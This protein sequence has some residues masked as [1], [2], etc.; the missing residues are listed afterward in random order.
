[1]SIQSFTSVALL[2]V[3]LS[4]T[5]A[6]AS[7][8][9]VTSYDMNNGNGATQYTTPTGGQNYFDFTYTATGQ[10]S[11]TS[12]AG[13]NG[14]ASSIPSNPSHDAPLTGGTGKLTDGI[15]ASDNYSLVSSSNGTISN[16]PA[17][18]G[19]L[20]GQ[21]TQYVGWKYQDPSIT[22]NLAS[23]HLISQISLY[24]AANGS[25]GLVGAPGNVTLNLGG[26]LLDPSLY[27]EVTSPYKPSSNPYASSTDVI[28]ITLKQAVSSD[29]AFGL[30]LFRGALE[31]D[32]D[33]YEA[34]YLNTTTNVFN[35]TLSGFQENAW[36]PKLEPW[37]MLSE[38]E[39]TSAVP[40]P[41]TWLMMIAGFVGLAFVARRKRAAALPQARI[42]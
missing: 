13:K 17:G 15:K 24:V 11:P 14:S 19:F 18:Y 42:A 6:L 9:P 40:E 22:F 29:L 16:S 23:G 4:S 34:Q 30:Q 2:A 35:D 32:G 27:T 33:A 1:M 38:V 39:F 25:G 37:I 28:T 20:N 12:N 21:A 3:C 36:D 31:A 7:V 8:V 10:S 41:S 26:V 5:S